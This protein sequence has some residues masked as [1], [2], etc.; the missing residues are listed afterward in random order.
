MLSEK[1]LRELAE[2]ARELKNHH[3]ELADKYAILQ[4]L[5]EMQLQEIQHK[6]AQTS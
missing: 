6:K 4:Y 2:D 3:Q 5:C 1:Q